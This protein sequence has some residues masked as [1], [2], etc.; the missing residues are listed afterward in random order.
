MYLPYRTGPV[1]KVYFDIAARRAA[2]EI[3][4][5]LVN[6]SARELPLFKAKGGRFHHG[7]P[8]EQKWVGKFYKVMS[9]KGVGKEELVS[10]K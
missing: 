2:L 4:L 9:G 3:S 10:I 1:R 6:F 7:S 8:P 5:P